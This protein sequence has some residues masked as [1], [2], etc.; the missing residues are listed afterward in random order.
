MENLPLKVLCLED[1]PRDAE[2]IR[3]LL[4]DAGFNINLDWTATE[5][6]YI[7]LLRGSTY[8]VI[9]SDFT[10]SGFDAFG[11]LRLSLDICPNVPFI[12]VSGSIGEET[13]IELLTHGAVDY[14]LKDRLAR[15]PAAITRALRE[16]KEK[17]A[18]GQTEEALRLLSSRQEAILASVPDIIMVYLGESCRL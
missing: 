10:L 1:S 2:I 3:E 7:S 6:E 13:A 8:D 12:C 4:T 9:L 16:A 17:E 15:L 14:V 11:A 5:K 18:R